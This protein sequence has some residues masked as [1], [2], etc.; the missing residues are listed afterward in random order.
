METGDSIVVSFL[1]YVCD[2]CGM[3]KDTVSVSDKIAS[4][5]GWVINVAVERMEKEVVMA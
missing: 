1:F 4:K 5:V 3:I 2:L